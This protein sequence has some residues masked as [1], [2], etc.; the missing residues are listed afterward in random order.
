MA[1]PFTVA[2]VGSP[3]LFNPDMPKAK[4]K[5]KMM[6]AKSILTIQPDAF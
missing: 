3:E 5:M 2:T 4:T 1:S 6:T